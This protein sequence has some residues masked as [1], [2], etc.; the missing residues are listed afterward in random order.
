MRVVKWHKTERTPFY[1]NIAIVLGAMKNIKTDISFTG[2][3]ISILLGR[4]KTKS[5]ILR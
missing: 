1:A 3:V 4:I 2:K 5:G